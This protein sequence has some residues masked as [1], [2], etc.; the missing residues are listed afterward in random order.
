MLSHTQK[1]LAAIPLD[2]PGFPA[3]LSGELPAGDFYD[4]LASPNGGA[5]R[6]WLDDEN[7]QLM[8]SFVF[9]MGSP[10]E[11]LARLAEL[12]PSGGEDIELGDSG[13]FGEDPGISNPTSFSMA[14]FAQGSFLGLTGAAILA[15]GAAMPS[16]ESV[17]ALAAELAA[18]LATV[19]AH[20]VS[21]H[22]YAL[23]APNGD[24]F[25]ELLDK[26]RTSSLTYL[27]QVTVPLKRGSVNNGSISFNLEITPTDIK[28]GQWEPQKPG[29]PSSTADSCDPGG[30]PSYCHIVKISLD[31]I[32]LGDYDGD[33]AG[34]GAGDLMAG[35]GLSVYF[36]RGI[37]TSK[38]TLSF[39]T[40]ELGDCDENSGITPGNSPETLPK[41]LKTIEACGMPSAID[42]DVLV[43]DNDEGA[44]VFDLITVLIVGA[45]EGGVGKST[46]EA[47]ADAMKELR[48]TTPDQTG[49]P[50]MQ[51][52]R[53]REGDD[54]GEAHDTQIH[55]M[56]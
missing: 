14:G 25:Q 1:M 20:G 28:C 51:E 40:G 19:P 9:D 37:K 4:G 11:A 15:E 44:D 26:T 49:T 8:L 16:Q 38:Q 18:G 35:G 45:A 52:L 39:A 34:R 46:G 36:K 30:P 2:C 3:P 6:Y 54:V 12:R 22:S 33:G 53:K 47:A 32:T 43:R 41:Y 24:S 42:F 55:I 17:L 13:W 10:E 21:H 31:S 48:K 23:V 7:H 5:C 56:D 50:G 29:I 27:K